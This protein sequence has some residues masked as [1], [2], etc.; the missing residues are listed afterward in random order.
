MKVG[1]EVKVFLPDMERKSKKGTVQAIVGVGDSNYKVLDVT[2]GS[3]EDAKLYE[4]VHHER[5][6]EE[7]SA[8]W[9]LFGEKALS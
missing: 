4:S 7:G 5:D 8:Y 1:Q 9:M 3:G 2:V 6:A